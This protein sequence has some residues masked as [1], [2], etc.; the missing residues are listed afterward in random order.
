MSRRL[1]LPVVSGPLA[2]YAAGCRLWL[3]ERGYTPRSVVNRLELLGQ[4]SRWLEVEALTT[5]ELTPEQVER[6]LE[7]RRAAGLLA[8]RFGTEQVVAA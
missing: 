3:L 7:R 8:V 2:P 1:W 6:F 4:L 5:V